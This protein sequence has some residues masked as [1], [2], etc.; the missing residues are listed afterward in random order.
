MQNNLAFNDSLNI[1]VWIIQ[2]SLAPEPIPTINRFKDFSL[3]VSN[4]I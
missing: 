3:Y 2:E 1:Q 4:L